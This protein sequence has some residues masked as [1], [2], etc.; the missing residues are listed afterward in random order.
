MNL[1]GYYTRTHLEPGEVVVNATIPCEDGDRWK[2][3]SQR[4]TAIL[5]AGRETVVDFHFPVAMAVVEGVVTDGGTPAPEGFVLAGLSVGDTFEHFQ[6]SCD[7]GGSYRFD[8]LPAGQAVFRVF[9]SERGAAVVIEHVLA[10]GA[11][12]R[13]DVD[14]ADHIRTA[15]IEGIVDGF[16]AAGATLAYL[17]LGTPD[18][19]VMQGHGF[20]GETTAICHVRIQDDGTFIM[21][22]LSKGAYTVEVINYGEL[23]SRIRTPRNTFRV[24]HVE[25]GQTASVRL[26]MP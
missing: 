21:D 7:D 9:P 17:H 26:P 2:G 19:G 16:Q 23:G 10:E 14:F 8:G 18:T 4:K 3:R 25:D 24:V 1:Q 15:R 20:F 12:V 11:S 22:G 13:L 5:A 6:A